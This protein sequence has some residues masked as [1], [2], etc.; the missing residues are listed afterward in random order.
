MDQLIQDLLAYGRIT[1]VELPLSK[2]SLEA[3]VDA[4]LEQL[5][6]EVTQR[7]AKIEVQR[8]LPEVRANAVVLEQ[9]LTNLLSNA[10]KFSQ[11]RVPPRVRIW[12]EPAD[13]RA[14]RLHVQDNGI[15]FDP[16]HAQRIF[17][18]FQRL[19]DPRK[20]PGT[21]IGLVIV[22]KGVERM[23]GHVGADSRP[24]HGAR[25]WIELPPAP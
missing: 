21:G 22:R 23:G 15:G 25:F 9:V 14:V 19:H 4:A 24:G 20:Y 5:R 10:L 12:A 2:V 17:G 3:E 18:M 7:Q 13:S 11:D 8:P 1:Q 6:R 16:A